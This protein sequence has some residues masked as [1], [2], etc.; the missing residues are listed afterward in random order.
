M[1]DRIAHS[2]YSRRALLRKATI[3]GAG[4]TSAG[5]LACNTRK[6]EPASNSA[7]SSNA[8][9][10][11]HVGGTLNVATQNVVTLDPHNRLTTANAELSAYLSRLFRYKS[12][13]SPQVAMNQDLENDL[14]LSAES[15]DAVTWTFKLRPGAR[16]HD[17][18]PVSGHAVE[19]EDVKATFSRS[20]NATTNPNRSTLSMINAAQIETPTADTV[21]FK[22]NYP[23]AGFPELLAA[24]LYSWILPR[25][26]L[27]GGYDPSKQAIGS[28][29]FILDSYTPDVAINFKRNPAWFEKGRPYVDAVHAVVLP[30]EAQQLAQFSAGHLDEFTPGT[31][32]YETVKQQMPKA[33]RLS[34]FTASGAGRPLYFQLGDPSSLF[35][36][37]RLRRAISLAIDRQAIGKALFD[38]Q[39]ALSFMIALGYGKWALKME[40]LPSETAQWYKYDPAQAKKLIS[41]TGADGLSFKYA[42]ISNWPNRS[43]QLNKQDFTVNNMLN[44]VGLKTTLVPLDF[45]KDFLGGGKGV[46]QGNFAK[47]TLLSGGVNNI[48][49]V[50]LVLFQYFDSKS[51]I[52][53]TRLHDPTLDAMMDKGRTIINTDERVKAYKEIQ[54]YIADKMY[55]VAGTPQAFDYR[56]VQPSVQGYNYSNNSAQYAETYSKL[57][58][59]R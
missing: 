39:Y 16:F 46:L 25:E 22:L 47:D 26:A 34:G 44:A 48:P 36:D 58:L 42:Y 40:D 27:A 50:D 19:A 45:V 15:S 54:K 59:Q 52:S 49:N 57:W 37:V 5:L 14:A 1:W 51:A 23:Y 35:Q 17:I 31:T 30:N 20:L 13:P 3:G 38:D 8:A 7:G 28:G 29:P 21:V 53:Q 4:L 33:Q 11:P 12:G 24:P 43:E 32:N 2:R 56:I 55:D 41:E 9:G 18:P 10:K 6:P